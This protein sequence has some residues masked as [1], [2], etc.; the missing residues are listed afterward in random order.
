[1]GPL[2]R[3]GMVWYDKKAGDWLPT[4]RTCR[5]LIRR[6]SVSCRRCASAL[7]DDAAHEE[8]KAAK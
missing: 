8:G 2:K 7:Q 5:R 1:M 6:S 3:C 4:V